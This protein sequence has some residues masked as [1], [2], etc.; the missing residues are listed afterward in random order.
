MMEVSL[1]GERISQPAFTT[2]DD[3]ILLSQELFTRLNQISQYKHP[4]AVR[5]GVSQMENTNTSRIVRA[6]AI[7]YFLDIKKTRDNK[8]FLMITESRYKGED[9]KRDRNTLVVFQDN[10]K[11]FAQA[12]TEMSAN[13]S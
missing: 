1:Y 12:I 7:T 10:A 4:F 11:Q 6:G 3:L 8:P 9:K 5:K 2:I 13:M